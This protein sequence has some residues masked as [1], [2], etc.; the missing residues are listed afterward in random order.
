MLTRLTCDPRY[1]MGIT[2]Q[3]EKLTK[4]Q[5]LRSNK[6]MSNEKKNLKRI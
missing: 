4:S 1:E 6:S 2:T 5:R 3:K